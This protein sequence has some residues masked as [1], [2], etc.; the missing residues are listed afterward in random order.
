M[1]KVLGAHVHKP[2]QHTLRQSCAQG[3]QPLLKVWSASA[4]LNDCSNRSNSN[5]KRYW[6]LYECT[7]MRIKGC[8]MWAI[9]RMARRY[10][11][12]GVRYL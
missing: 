11:G 7:V 8:G 4:Y 5:R 12:P 1:F 2:H 10:K 3:L 6:P 9:S